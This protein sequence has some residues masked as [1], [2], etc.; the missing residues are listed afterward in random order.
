MRWPLGA[1]FLCVACGSSNEGR[2]SSVTPGTEA[3]SDAT[4]EAEAGT[5][6]DVLPTPNGP[7]Q[8]VCSG[9]T[10]AF[11]GIPYAAPPVGELRWRPPRAPVAWTEPRPAFEYG[12]ECAQIAYPSGE[13]TGDE[14][15]LTLNVWLP[16]T[17]PAQP[18]PILVWLHGGDNIIGSSSAEQGLYDGRYLSEHVPA[19]VVT[20]NYRLA[21]FG[22]MANPAFAVEN[23]EGASGNYGV[24]DQIFALQW[25]KENAGSLGGDPERVLL[26]G[27]S[28]GASDTCAVL[29]SPLA[30]GLISRAMMISLSCSVVSPA[31]INATN[32]AAEEYLGCDGATDM[33]SCLRGKSQVEVGNVPGASLAQA[34]AGYDYY[35]VV[36][37]RVLLDDPEAVLASGGHSHVPVM[38]G[39]TRDEYAALVELLVDPIPTTEAEYAASLTQLFGTFYDDQILAL[40]PLSSYASPHAALAASLSDYIMH[41]PTG[42]ATRALASGQSE[43]VWRYVFANPFSTGPLAEPG[44]AHGYDVPFYFHNFTWAVPADADVAFSEAVIPYLARFA[45]TG[46]PNGDGAAV[47]PAWDATQPYLEL[48]P[49]F[50]SG[51]DWRGTECEFWDSVPD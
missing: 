25:I 42:R 11:K 13:F 27:Q 20:L 43:P 41:C 40:Y 15:C 47:W 21:A 14:D 22:F 37:G 28:A 4:I 3:G 5:S 45:N 12:A 32:T 19:I 46:D 24:L 34:T 48:S 36:D 6:A 38:L 8:G 16:E 9:G 33:A 35:T 23:P 26:F 44:A 49:A 18:L 7:V 50:P 51:T 2:P 10:C 30:K 39:T 29:A 17:K 31:M 1:L